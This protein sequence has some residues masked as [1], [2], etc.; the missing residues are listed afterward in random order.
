VYP[1]PADISQPS[2]NTCALAYAG[3]AG[4][5]SDPKHAGRTHRRHG[6]CPA[7]TS[8]NGRTVHT[9]D[10]A[11]EDELATYVAF[12]DELAEWLPRLRIVPGNHDERELI[13]RAFPGACEHTGDRVIGRSAI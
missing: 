4:G 2:A 9:G 10:T 13:L 8:A 5:P 3:R 6:D 1:D 12:R 7:A 11:N